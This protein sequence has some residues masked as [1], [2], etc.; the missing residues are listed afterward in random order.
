MYIDSSK[1]GLKLLELAKG[2]PPKARKNIPTKEAIEPLY[3]TI[4]QLTTGKE[5]HSWEQIADLLKHP[6]ID[7]TR[8]ASTIHKRFVEI[9]REREQ[10]AKLAEKA[11]QGQ[12]LATANKAEATSKSAK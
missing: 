7:I 4:L 2:L 12:G 10:Q 9:T 11:K 8:K 5:P 6:E 3:G 1:A